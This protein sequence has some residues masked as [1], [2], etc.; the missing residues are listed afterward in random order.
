MGTIKTIITPEILCY[1]GVW[2]TPNGDVQYVDFCIITAHY[3]TFSVERQM[4][5]GDWTAAEGL[6]TLSDHHT[7]A[8]KDEGI[9]YALAAAETF[10]ANIAQIAEPG[11]QR[12]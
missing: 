11:D 9:A 12:W 4:P 3:K 2:W 5:D 1:D 7:F 8:D 6:R 10:V